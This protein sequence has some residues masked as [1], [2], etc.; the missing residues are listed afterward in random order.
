MT[1]FSLVILFEL[2][3]VYAEQMFKTMGHS[4]VYPNPQPQAIDQVFERC[5]I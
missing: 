1:I 2:G 3:S 4:I 5:Y